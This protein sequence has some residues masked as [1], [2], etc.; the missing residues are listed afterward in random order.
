MT[1]DEFKIII[2]L[3]V[4]YAV[5]YYFKSSLLSNIA[6]NA[7]VNSNPIICKTVLSYFSFLNM[8]NYSSMIL[9]Y[10]VIVGMN[11]FF[12]YYLSPEVFVGLVISYLFGILKIYP[13]I[14]YFGILAISLFFRHILNEREIYK[15]AYV[16]Q[17]N[18]NN[19]NSQIYYSQQARLAAQERKY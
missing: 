11:S 16:E 2:G 4:I 1:E 9:F 17:L 13:I 19:H 6:L 18:I 12:L 10:A 3:C 8:D 15:R 5:L 14:T 7:I